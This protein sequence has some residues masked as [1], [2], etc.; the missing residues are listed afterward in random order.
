MI[1]ASTMFQAVCY[2]PDEC[3]LIT[4]GTDRK[5]GYW[6]VYDGSQIRELEG[7][8]TGSINGIDISSCGRFF[9]TGGDDRVVKVPHCTGSG[10]LHTLPSHVCSH[11]AVSLCRVPVGLQV[12]LYNEGEVT[13]AGIGHSGNITRVRMSPDGQ[14]VVSV[15][16]D[17]GILRWR[18]PHGG[19][20]SGST[21]QQ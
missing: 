6:E 11:S 2:L 12:W 15:S 9:V 18:L 14:H 3:Q 20:D 4:G 21:D 7:S 13:H 19:T 5:V 17:G 16:E 1:F 8:K 10:R